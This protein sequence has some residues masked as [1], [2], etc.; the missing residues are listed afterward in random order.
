MFFTSIISIISGMVSAMFIVP[1]Q[2]VSKL[3]VIIIGIIVFMYV[4]NKVIPIKN[5]RNIFPD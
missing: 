4:M 3:W 2:L 5:Y 1:D